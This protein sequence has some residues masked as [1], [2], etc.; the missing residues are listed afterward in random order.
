GREERGEYL[1]A[2]PECNPHRHLRAGAGLPPPG[3]DPARAQRVEHG[4]QRVELAVVARVPFDTGLRGTLARGRALDGQSQILPNPV[5]P[6]GN[7]WMAG[8]DAAHGGKARVPAEGAAAR[9]R[10]FSRAHGRRQGAQWD[11]R[12][13]CAAP[14][15]LV[16]WRQR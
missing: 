2:A 6:V 13:G 11:Q 5:L 12:L 9:A 1:A 10:R 8:K 3:W 16:I 7:A 4:M 15:L 14:I